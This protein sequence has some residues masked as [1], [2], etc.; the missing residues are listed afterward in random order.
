GWRAVGSDD[1]PRG[2]R[3][4]ANSGCICIQRTGEIRAADD[5]GPRQERRS[6]RPAFL[7]AGAASHFQHCHEIT[8]AVRGMMRAYA[9]Q[10]GNLRLFCLIDGYDTL[11]ILKAYKKCRV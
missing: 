7:R 6:D 4:K 8:A 1:E 3:R 2:A 5:C 9:Q 10:M 11:R